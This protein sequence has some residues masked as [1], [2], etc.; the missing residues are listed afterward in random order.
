MLVYGSTRCTLQGRPCGGTDIVAV[1]AP[2][3]TNLVRATAATIRVKPLKIRLLVA[4]NTR[5]VRI[6]L[7]PHH[8][9]RET[10]L[11]TARLL[12]HL[13]QPEC[14]PRHDGN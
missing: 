11:T 10:F 3:G 4:R 5:R 8:P 7:A 9:P 6:L 13:I 12:T 2:N 1:T 14:R